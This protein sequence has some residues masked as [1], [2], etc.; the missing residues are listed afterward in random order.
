MYIAQF[1]MEGLVKTNLCLQVTG[2]S[3]EA[4]DVVRWTVGEREG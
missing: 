4:V 1:L 3:K 2:G